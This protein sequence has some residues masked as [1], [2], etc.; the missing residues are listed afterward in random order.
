MGD[1]I[2]ATVLATNVIG[3]SVASIPGSGAV[4]LTN[5]GVPSLLSN[6]LASTTL[7]AIAI[8]WIAPTFLGGTALIDY[9]I[10]WD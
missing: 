10:S 1:S 9:R 7:S 4:I 6:D 8:K 5:P 2:Y 3:S